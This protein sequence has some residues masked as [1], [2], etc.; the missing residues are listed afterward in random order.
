[1]EQAHRPLS[2]RW[3]RWKHVLE[4]EEII[5]L[6]AVVLAVIGIAITEVSPVRSYHYWLGMIVVFAMVALALG[7]LKARR[8]GHDLKQLL[9]VQLLHWVATWV[10]VL[11]LFL[12]LDAGRLNYDNVGLVTLT[13]LA[14]STVL[15]GIR[16]DWRFSM[17]GLLLGATA[18][19]VAY[20][21]ASIWLLIV[22]AALISAAIVVYGYLRR[23]KARGH[24]KE[25]T[26]ASP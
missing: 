10:A 14:L 24:A 17:V 5:L 7:W 11:A 8:E 18:V 2:Q 13:V 1:M 26:E 25:N 9:G 19:T 6:A 12:I 20:V 15:E 22:L 21:E 4:L 3:E 23:S 16:V